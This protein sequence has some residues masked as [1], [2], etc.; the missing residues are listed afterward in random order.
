MTL[1]PWSRFTPEQQRAAFLIDRPVLATAGAGA[2][3]TAV[4]A[5]RWCACLLDRQGDGFLAPDR[6]LA[7][8]FTREAAG[9]LRARIDRTLRAVLA[10]GV[11]PRLVDGEGVSDV[12]L[13]PEARAHL[14]SALDALAGAPITTVDG[15]C[16][17]LAAEHAAELG[18][19]PELAVPDEL[20]WAGVRDAA[21]RRVRAAQLAA[22]GG[23]LV[24]L[25]KAWGEERVRSLVEGLAGRA[26]A[27]PEPLLVAA[28]FDPVALLLERRRPQ[29]ARVAADLDALRSIAKG[30]LGAAL[31]GI[32][33]V[34]PTAPKLL[35]PWLAGVD[36]LK[37]N[38]VKDPAAKELVNGLRAALAFPASGKAPRYGSLACLLAYDPVAEVAAQDLALRTARLA[39]A[40]L[41]AAHAAADDRGLAGF[42]ATAAAALRLLED[43]AIR[44]RLA[45]RWRHALVDEA[46]DLNRLQGR[47]I[48]ALEGTTVF[49]VGDGRQSIFGFRH[50]EPAV[51][52]RWRALL[53]ER[54][55]AVCALAENFRSHPGLVTQV[56]DL[57]SQPALVA[58]FEPDLIKPGREAEG[59][60]LCSAWQV[61]PYQGGAPA[62]LR[63]R[64]TGRSA[65]VARRVARII[66][67]SLAAGRPPEAHAILLRHR[68]RMRLYAAALE[69]AGIPY[70]TDFPVGLIGSQECHDIE[71]VLR[72]ACARHD[73]WALA[74][75]V[76]GPWGAADPADRTLLVEALEAEPAAGW[77]LVAERTPLGALVGEVAMI[78]AERGPAAA[79][80]RLALDARL[81]A[82][83]GGLPLAR[84]RLANLVRLAAED[85][86]AGRELDVVAWL[87][88]LAERRRLGVDDAEASGA[89]IGGRGVRLMTIHGAKG[90]EWPVVL[91]PELDQP[92]GTRDLSAPVVAQADGERLI[93][94]AQPGA[95][96]DEE[97]EVRG[98]RAE[99]LAGEE[100]QRLQAEE[101]RLFYVALTRARDELHLLIGG[102]APQT[103]DAAGLCGAMADWIAGAGWTWQPAREDL[104]QPGP[105]APAVATAVAPLPDLVRTGPATVQVRGVTALAEAACPAPAPVT[106]WD[107]DLAQRLGIA[108][109]ALL[110]EHGP[111]VDLRLVTTALVPLAADLGPERHA[112]LCAALA[113]PGLLPGYWQAAARLVEQPVIGALAPL[114]LVH[115]IADLLLQDATGSWRLYDWKTG[116]G[117]DHAAAQVQLQ[118]YV[119]LLAPHLDG[120]LV[121]AWLIDVEARRRIAVDIA[122]DDLDQAWERLGA[123]WT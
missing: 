101:A 81:T 112:R 77:A 102:D 85:E 89:A 5:V 18:R 6:I 53:P 51:F 31:A 12:E 59:T 15:F 69:A 17:Q 16:L 94:A 3:K 71:A 10:A 42:A 9:N 26:S 116:R 122:P 66:C 113:D 4:M 86:H 49:T 108:V 84:R 11:F 20:A 93:L 115:G 68:S 40:W 91:L 90:L 1:L 23:D 32:A 62:D 57:L 114:R 25:A 107:R 28:D 29:L 119:R 7:L 19:D 47:L 45:G 52:A 97:L 123:V 98:L 22:E 72:L 75:A 50:A 96:D 38:G 76:G 54:G 111:G 73:R 64:T 30:A 21:W 56:V 61:E 79:V 99:L 82:R 60:A 95:E 63:P 83:Y 24:V 46:Q 67:A 58:D 8:A 78:L 43:P 120:P 117:A 65:A 100:R 44:R 13:G 118:A 88:R 14:R 27:L 74:V 35:I 39:G 106:G 70:D 110:A 55:G 48:E 104:D 2:G 36:G 33:P 80:R 37:L 103:P 121:E 92:F 105:T 109:H 34:M 41:A 87:E